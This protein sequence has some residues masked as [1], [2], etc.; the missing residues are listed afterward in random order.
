ME[1]TRVLFDQGVWLLNCIHFCSSVYSSWE[2]G[3]LQCFS[4]IKE[5]YG[6][7]SVRFCAI[8]DGNEECL[9]AEKMKWP[10]VSIDLDPEGTHRFPGLQTKTLGFYMDVVYGEQPK[11]END[12][13]S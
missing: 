7:L 3:K 11:H 4:W 13:K 12:N 8:G 5:K 6:G 9:A 1:A 10:F 2:V